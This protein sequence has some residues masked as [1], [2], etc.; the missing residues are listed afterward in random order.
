MWHAILLCTLLNNVGSCQ[1]I[2]LY[3]TISATGSV[4]GIGD[5]VS[6]YFADLGLERSEFFSRWVE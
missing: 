5:P 1:Y 4:C 2:F 6:L 3:L